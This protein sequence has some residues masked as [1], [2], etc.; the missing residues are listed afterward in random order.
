MIEK[1]NS[2]DSL[3]EQLWDYDRKYRAGEP[4]ISD[5]EYDKLLRR[6]QELELQSGEPIPL[7]SPTQRVGNDVVSG[8]ETLPHR[9][10]MLS[11]ENTYNIGELR[12][13]GRKVDR[14]FK[15]DSTG[16]ETANDNFDQNKNNEDN[17]TGN[18]NKVDEKNAD[19]GWVVELK[20][21]GVA[22]TLIYED[23][24]L[25]RGLTRGNG[26]S[27]DDITHN[28]RTIKDIPL[29]LRIPSGVQ[30]PKL[31]EVRGEVYMR[32][33]DLTILNQSQKAAGQTTYA[34]TRNVTAG[35]IRLLDSRICS[36]RRLRFF[37]HSVGESDGLRA[38]N[39][40][41]FLRE[42]ES[43]GISAT[44]H[45]ALFKTFSEAADYCESLYE[46]EDNFLTSLDF[47]IDG[48][49]LKV[50]DFSLRKR[51]GATSKYPR[52]VIAYKVE[53]YE[54]V[55]RLERIS[56]QVG[57][58][59]VITPVAELTPVE[60][61]GTTVSRASLH[62]AD[63]IERKD[64]RAGDIVVVEKAGKIIPHLVRVEKH[65]REFE[66]N[67]YQFPKNCP[68]CESVLIKDDG[69]VYIRCANPECPAQV[70][71]R[72]GYFASRAAM[73]IEGLGDKLINQL[74]DNGL[75]S[76]FGDIYRLSEEKL[77]TGKIE[78]MG[79][80]LAEKL[81]NNIEKSKNRDL[82]RFLNALSIRHVGTGTAKLLAK[83]FGTITRLQN[84]TEEEISCVDGVGEIIAASL[85]QFLHSDYGKKTID[86]L[87]SEFAKKRGG[88]N[89]KTFFDNE[90]SQ[91]TLLSVKLNTLLGNEIESEKN[92]AGVEL[93]DDLSDG[94]NQKLPLSGLTIVVT[95]TLDRFSRDEIKS[96]I[97]FY[98][99]KAASSVSSNTSFVVTG[100]KAGNTKLKQA[101][102]L[103]IKI[104]D[105]SEFNNIINQTKKEV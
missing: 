98:G 96:V 97:E 71:E 13:F 24:F 38:K 72:I 4:V 94:G 90:Y 68:A 33:S 30:P 104:I 26:I 35:S 28:I 1:E 57:K 20:I 52:W 32:N 69:G 82:A 84:A 80:R 58:T 43:Y 45:A 37:A 6:L 87:I 92:D 23:G 47:E 83:H 56:V 31:L 19:W 11:I 3:R 42:I 91:T 105:E 67:E 44:P 51:L 54:A 62:N 101:E 7:D 27:G 100:K 25:V 79:K 86:D 102:K 40:F 15:S 9:V 70:K 10:P 61:A 12:E 14:H 93:S 60:L 48:L 36:G 103:G 2:L 77:E 64:I 49:V 66:N 5:L 41:D 34:N 76:N 18:K 8:L 22:A 59:G 73:D 50:N 65:L 81:M 63:E 99:G 17:T 46:N 95:G 78:R 29:R 55:T 85:Y 39:H 53:K 75:V 16:G 89:Q 21:D 88:G 74:V